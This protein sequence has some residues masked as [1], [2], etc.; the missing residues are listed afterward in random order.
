MNE[1]Q[2]QTL[3]ID[4]E[5][6]EETID[7]VRELIEARPQESWTAYQVATLTNRVFEAT[8]TDK[9]VPTQMM[10]NYTRNGMIAKGKKG[11][12]TDIRYTTDEVYAFVT[13]YTSKFVNVEN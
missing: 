4:V 2:I 10:Y 7:V 5:T 3:A 13:K 9:K 8:E 1:Q 11:K 12:A 6:D